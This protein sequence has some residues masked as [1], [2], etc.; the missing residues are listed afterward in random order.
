MSVQRCLSNNKKACF[1]MRSTIIFCIL[2]VLVFGVHGQSVDRNQYFD[3][4]NIVPSDFN[5]YWSH[6]EGC[7]HLL[8]TN[9][10]TY[11]DSFRVVYRPPFSKY[12]IGSYYLGEI[13]EVDSITTSAPNIPFWNVNHDS[14]LYVYALF[15]VCNHYYSPYRKENYLSPIPI[16]IVDDSVR[17]YEYYKCLRKQMYDTSE[18]LKNICIVV[19]KNEIEK[20]ILNSEGLHPNQ[21]LLS[22]HDDETI[23]SGNI[24][25]CDKPFFEGYSTEILLSE[26]QIT[27]F[28]LNKYRYLYSQIFKKEFLYPTE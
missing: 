2:T 22:I 5:V 27:R 3:Y 12:L 14:I 19:T 11:M 26:S 10:Y 6:D 9:C 23:D 18:C 4:N 7:G 28:R 1:I 24:L 20:H 17:N 15:R 16:D 25:F 13:V 8:Y 21:I